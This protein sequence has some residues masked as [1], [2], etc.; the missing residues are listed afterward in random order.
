M[1]MLV[2]YHIRYSKESSDSIAFPSPTF[3]KA[4]D[5]A[6][7]VDQI[8]WGGRAVN[9]VGAASLHRLAQ[10]T[11]AATYRA[12][13]GREHEYYITTGDHWLVAFFNR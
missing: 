9:T 5:G 8:L 7:H 4:G 11:A 12:T 13:E 10:L 1:R 6:V 2:Q 3:A